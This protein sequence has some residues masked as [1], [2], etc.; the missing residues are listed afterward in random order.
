MHWS[1]DLLQLQIQC[2]FW[3]W[4]RGQENWQVSAKPVAVLDSRTK[5]RERMECRMWG[6]VC[7][8][9]YAHLSFSGPVSVGLSTKKEQPQS[10]RGLLLMQQGAWKYGGMS[11]MVSQQNTGSEV[12]PVSF[13]VSE[14]ALGPQTYLPL[15]QA[16]SSRPLWPSRI[17]AERTWLFQTRGAQHRGPQCSR[18][19]VLGRRPLPQQSSTSSVSVCRRVV[20][21]C[22]MP[23]F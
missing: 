20:L 23:H 21:L 13:A 18:I 3:G 16:P 17:R 19:A 2:S 9:V 12:L 8:M 15:R 4:S 11:W 7:K 1:E 14:K 6:I 22:F 10:N 5:H